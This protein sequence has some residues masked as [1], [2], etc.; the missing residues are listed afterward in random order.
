MQFAYPTKVKR[1]SNEAML[2]DWLFHM[3]NRGEFGSHEI[4]TRAITHFL[5]IYNK[6]VTPDTISRLWRKMREDY[7]INKYTSSLFDKGLEVEEV[8]KPNSRQ[9]YYKVNLV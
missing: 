6:K 2:L 4:Q 7:K 9:K 3:A 8:N 5:N 1:H